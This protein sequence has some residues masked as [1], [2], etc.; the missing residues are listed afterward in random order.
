MSPAILLFNIEKR[1]PSNQSS[2]IRASPAPSSFLSFSLMDNQFNICDEG[3][4]GPVS[5]T[6]ML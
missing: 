5:V 4:V 2:W 6:E 3:L 1:S